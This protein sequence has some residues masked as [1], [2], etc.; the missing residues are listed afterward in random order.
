AVGDLSVTE[1]NSG[2]TSATFTVT[3]SG[4]TSGTS[5]V[6]YATVAATAVAPSDFTAVSGTLTFG[7]GQ[8]TKSVTVS[9]IADTANEANETFSLKLSSPLGAVISDP[10]GVVTI[11]NDDPVPGPTTFLTVNDVSITEGAAATSAFVTFTITR[12]GV[13]TGS[14]TVTYA[15]ANGT[16][17]SG[18]D[19]KAKAATAVT[20]AAG[21]TTKT[22]SVKV[23]GDATVEP[24]ETFKL[25][26][27]SPT[28]AT[29][30]DGTGIATIVN[31]D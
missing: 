12:S 11:V 27:S 7:P 1:G 30:S 19:Y 26:L 4:D 16:A 10:K 29:I 3:R 20:F 31:D 5:K 25:K 8:T 21:E 2:T 17:T 15:T 24:D 22:V 23:F 18:S 13:T 9:V 28:G 14:S 6:T